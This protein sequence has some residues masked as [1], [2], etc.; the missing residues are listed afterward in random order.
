MLTMC[1]LVPALQKHSSIFT[2]KSPKQ[3]YHK[4]EFP[5]AGDQR[6]V[7]LQEDLRDFWQYHPG[8]IPMPSFCLPVARF[9]PFRWISRLVKNLSLC[10][11]QK[12]EHYLF[13]YRKEKS[14]HKRV[15]LCL[16]LTQNHVTQ[17]IC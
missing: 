16:T 6:M 5:V 14:S 8:M 7:I 13:S 1:P 2:V 9:L 4:G 15:L 3:G 12:T 10:L 17:E 11:G